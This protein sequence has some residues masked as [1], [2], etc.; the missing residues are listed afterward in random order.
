MKQKGKYY[1]VKYIT[2][3]TFLSIDSNVKK[4]EK[5]KKQEYRESC[6]K[7]YAMSGFNKRLAYFKLYS[8]YKKRGKDLKNIISREKFYEWIQG[9]EN[10][11]RNGHPDPFSSYREK[12]NEHDDR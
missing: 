9:Y 3:R 8:I 5:R 4:E 6:L 1:D 2:E 12:G 10:M 7:L 11:V